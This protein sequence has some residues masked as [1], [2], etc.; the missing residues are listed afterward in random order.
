MQIYNAYEPVQG[1]LKFIY[2]FAAHIHI[3]VCCSVLQ[4]VVVC[5]SVLLLQCVATHIHPI[6]TYIRTLRRESAEASLL[7]QCI[8]ACVL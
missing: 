8:A 4:C 1:N 3:A 6:Y 7:L 2:I 5:Y